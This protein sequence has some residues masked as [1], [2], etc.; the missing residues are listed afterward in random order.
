MSKLQRSTMSFRRQGSSG[1]IWNDP[2]RGAEL[3]GVAVP[4]PEPVTS[5]PELKADAAVAVPPQVPPAKKKKRW[6]PR[7][8][9]V[10]FCLCGRPTPVNA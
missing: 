5:I 6:R 10:G 1:R 9:S 3:T 8:W 4:V 2:V 7:P